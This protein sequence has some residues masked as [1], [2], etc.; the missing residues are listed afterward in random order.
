[1]S[2]YS[3][4]AHH[5]RF[6]TWAAVT[7]ARSS[8]L[9][10]FTRDQGLLLVKES[11]LAGISPRWLDLPDPSAFDEFHRDLRMSICSSARIALPTDKSDISHGIAAKLI[12]VYFKTLFLS[13]P[14]LEEP[15]PEAMAKANALHP[16][17][18]RLL[19]TELTI[20]NVGGRAKFWRKMRDKGWSRFDSDDYESIIEQ[21]SRVTSGALWT[22]E[23]H[24]LDP[25]VSRRH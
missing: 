12:N 22:I 18:D 23:E 8:S 16:P 1:M 20:K 25:E 5:Q 17:I 3:L 14:A 24:W 21:I 9:C 19:L 13:A 4:H 15:S 2:D 10:R 11:G 7:A 6:A